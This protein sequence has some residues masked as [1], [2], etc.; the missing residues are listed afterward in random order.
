MILLEDIDK[1]IIKSD[2]AEL[3]L[4]FVAV[5]VQLSSKG[6]A[7]HC[8]LIISVNGICKLFHFN[9]DDEIHLESVPEGKWYFHKELAIIS[10]QEAEVFLSRCEMILDTANPRFGFFYDGSYYDEKGTLVS[11]SN[12]S[13]YT[14]CVLFCINVILGFIESDKYI[15]FSDWAS[16][17]VSDGFFL[18]FSDRK[19]KFMATEDLEKL[20]AILLRIPPL[21]Y[22]ATA[23]KNKLP[24]GKADIADE[25]KLLEQ[26]LLSRVVSEV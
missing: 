6:V 20:R 21:D 17:A 2:S 5:A 26:V 4:N 18:H 14:N 25:V 1:A 10:P 23:F 12:Q 8:G 24:I 9:I 16:D 19:K 22:T 15:S 13:E 7:T 3:P 11:K